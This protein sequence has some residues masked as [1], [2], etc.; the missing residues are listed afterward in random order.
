MM[1]QYKYKAYD[2]AGVVHEGNIAAISIDSAKFKLKDQGFI[3]VSVRVPA[4]TQPV[5]HRLIFFVRNKKPGLADI[6]LWS[7]QMALLL[8][9]GV[10][11][12]RALETA[13]NAV[14]NQALKKITGQIYENVRSG[15]SL[16]ESV[17]M[18]PDVF[19]TLYVN[20]ID[21]GEATGR[22]AE[23]F[24]EL[25]AN[26]DFRK[27][28]LARTRQAMAYPIV[29]SVICLLS[30]VFIFNFIVPRFESLFAR[31]PD[32]PL[33]TRLLLETA[34]FFTRYQWL[35][36]ILAGFVPFVFGRLGKFSLLRHLLDG[37]VL[38]LPITRHLVYTLENLRFASSMA[39]MLNSGVLL[40]DA[41]GY[42][43]A[44]VGNSRIRQRLLTVKETVQ[45]GE[46]LSAAM[47]KTGFLPEAYAGIIEVGEQAGRLALIFKDMEG[48]MRSAYEQRLNSLITLIE[49]LMILL[50]GLIVGAIVVI[51]LLST[52]S[53]NEI[54][55]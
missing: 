36:L 34:H 18:H 4:V 46:K 41:L 5:F 13:R 1:Q 16:A 50:M 40:V 22:L 35:G 2:R 51:M 49:P 39:M 38:K 3:P 47:S 32:P 15:M 20:V 24:S 23:A 12:D 45:Q 55:L 53:L 29:I 37:L 31:M 11:V 26:L 54:S 21:I 7:S 43:V 42:A 48:R 30:V 8:H 27:Q 6:E 33:A 14:T 52:I 10:K 9:N 17:R 44:S 25:A 19:D 28:V